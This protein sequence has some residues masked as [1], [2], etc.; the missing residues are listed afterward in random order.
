[1]FDTQLQ[2]FVLVDKY[3]RFN[4]RLGRR[5]TWEETVNRVTSF[6][7]ELSDGKLSQDDYDK[8]YELIFDG[9]VSPS[10]RL[11]A[12][13]GKA[14]R[15]NHLLIYNCSYTP[16][17]EIAVFGELLW[18]SM[19]AV[20]VGYSVENRYINLLPP[21]AVVDRDCVPIEHV[22]EDSAE[23]WVHAFNLGVLCWWSGGDVVFDYSKIRPSGTPLKTKGGT[24]SGPQVLIDLMNNTKEIIRNNSGEKLSSVDVFDLITTIGYAAVSGGVRRSAQ[25]CLFDYD[26]KNMLNAK[27]GNF[28][29]HHPNRVNANISAVWNKEMTYQ[30]I[31]SQMETMFDGMSG[32]PGIVSRRS[33]N[34]TR[35]SWRRE[36]VHGGLNPC[37][38]V[39]L[40]GST[41]DGRFG[42]QLCN[43][44]SVNMRYDMNI[45]QLEEAVKYATIIGTIQAMATD[46]RL[47]R[48]EWK[49]ICE[50]ERILGVS[51]VG[52]CDIEI[53]RMPENL[54]HLKQTSIDTNVEYAKKLGINR[55]ASLTCSKPAGSSS[56]M[57]GTARGINPRYSDY[58][59]RRV[60][61]GAKTPVYRLMKD[62]GF[63]MSPENGQENWDEPNVYVA[64]FYEKSPD[65]AI[66]VDG[67]DAMKQLDLWLTVKKH[68][69]THNPSVT[70]E[71]TEEDR[72]KIVKWLFDNQ[73]YV[74][75]IAMLPR[76]EH[77]YQQ[78]P[79]TKIS[80]EQYE[81]GLANEPNLDWSVLYKYES[82]DTT[83][84]EL[85]CAGQTCD[86]F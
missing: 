72:D 84:K 59:E 27:T 77:V 86:L 53:A 62:Q 58:Y 85:E 80:K 23:G 52:F 4:E 3:S 66:T 32:E 41:A 56:S 44:S 5:E 22:I 43:L 15:K 83:V 40:H 38:E 17:T 68:W 78:A 30:E 48:K 70:I 19:S 61:V 2:K 55:A 29:E 79:Y 42:G 49:E 31:L 60:R 8:I 81:T 13:A 26:D 63:D 14:A 39:N 76:S 20:G 33:M 45:E 16:V 47:L 35:P 36:L 34:M 1:M 73:D 37:A 12:T 46:F 28:W 57:Y 24:A 6:L 82:S 51:L 67:M 50:E 21:V 64:T 65:G 9:T 10:M 69:T 7:I 74:N 11:M 25:I 18:L 75:G 71:Y 54:E